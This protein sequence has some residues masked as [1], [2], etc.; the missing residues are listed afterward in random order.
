MKKTTS[1][2]LFCVVAVAGCAH[3]KDAEVVDAVEPPATIRV[4]IVVDTARLQSAAQS[5]SAGIAALGTL[6]SNHLATVGLLHEPEVTST[7]WSQ[8]VELPAP[9][10]VLR[11]QIFAQ[12]ELMCQLLIEPL[13]TSPTPHAVTAAP[14]SVQDALAQ[15]ERGLGTLEPSKLPQME[16]LRFARLRAEAEVA[17][18]DGGDAPLTPE[19][20]VHTARPISADRLEAPYY[21]PRSEPS[22]L[23]SPPSQAAQ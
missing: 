9:G 16:P 4:S 3:A 21:A 23:L 6:I 18:R 22:V 8:T 19:A 1:I 15:V 5:A 2:A 11:A 14:W 17:G 7:R 13:A 12:P 20:Y 10:W